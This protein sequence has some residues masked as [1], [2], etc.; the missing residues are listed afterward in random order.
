MKGFDIAQLE[1]TWQRHIINQFYLIDF[2]KY[3]SK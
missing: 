2:L 3:F 1:V